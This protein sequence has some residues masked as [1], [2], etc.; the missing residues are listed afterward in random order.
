[1]RLFVENNTDQAITVYPKDASV[2]GTMTQFLSG[3]PMTIESGKNSP[4]PFF[5]T[6]SNLN[7]DKMSDVK[8]LEFKLWVTDKDTNTL[9]ET[10]ALSVKV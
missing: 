2:N 4:Q 3:V 6:Y 7:I 9:L 8:N 1:M 10:G 5:F